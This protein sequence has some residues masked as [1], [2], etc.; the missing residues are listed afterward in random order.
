MCLL[1]SSSLIYNQIGHISDQ[2]LENLTLI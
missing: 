1:L 2:A